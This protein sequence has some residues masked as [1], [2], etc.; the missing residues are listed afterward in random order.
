VATTAKSDEKGDVHKL[1]DNHGENRASSG[2]RKKEAFQRIGK[3]VQVIRK[4]SQLK[5]SILK[6]NEGKKTSESMWRNYWCRRA[7]KKRKPDLIE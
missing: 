1:M 3:K 6:K 2:K 7:P 5:I 4:K